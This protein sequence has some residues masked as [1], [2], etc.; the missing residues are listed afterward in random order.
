MCCWVK[1]DSV[2]LLRQCALVQTSPVHKHRPSENFIRLQ[3]TRCMYIV[4]TA[5]GQAL[6]QMSY[7]ID[8]T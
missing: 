6:S 4:H 7:S 8:I 2:N 5:R 3:L 1:D